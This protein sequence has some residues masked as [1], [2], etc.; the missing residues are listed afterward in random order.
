[1]REDQLTKPVT[2]KAPSKKADPDKAFRSMLESLFT[3]TGI[4]T[5][6]GFARFLGISYQGYC[7]WRAGRFPVDAFHKR[8][9]EAYCLLP[10]KELKNLVEERGVE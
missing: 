8:A 3:L 5:R 1:M 10:T 4:K 9:I 6:T 7:N 2:S